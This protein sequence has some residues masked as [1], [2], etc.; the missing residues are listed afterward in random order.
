MADIGLRRRT[1]AAGYGPVKSRS[2]RIKPVEGA[3]VGVERTVVCGQ[4]SVAKRGRRNTARPTRSNP[5]KPNQTK[6]NQIKPARGAEWPKLDL[7]G[8]RGRRNT[9]RSNP[10]NP[11]Q[12]GSNLACV[13]GGKGI[14]FD[15]D[16]VYD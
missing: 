13:D 12:T 8:V 14:H 15:Y 9:A 2:N 11:N 10:V 4:W 16:D 7:G 1:W 6:S 5:V 3:G